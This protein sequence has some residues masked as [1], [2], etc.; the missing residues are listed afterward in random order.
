M[1]HTFGQFTFDADRRTLTR[2]GQTTELGQRAC[3]LLM[4]LLQAEGQPVAK[5][6]LR[7]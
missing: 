2:D 1:T 6:A 5:A 4:A 3:A 7:A